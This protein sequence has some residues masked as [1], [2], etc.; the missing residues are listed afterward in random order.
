MPCQG[1]RK[2][3]K[4]ASTFNWFHISSQECVCDVTVRV[5]VRLQLKMRLQMNVAAG[6]KRGERGSKAKKFNSKADAPLRR[7]RRQRLHAHY[8]LLSAHL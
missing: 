7:R 2:V 1:V 8:R 4:S 3:P 5:C 6:K